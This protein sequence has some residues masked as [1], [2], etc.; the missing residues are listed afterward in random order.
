MFLAA[1]LLAAR[2]L[3]TASWSGIATASWFSCTS[4]FATA[5]WIGSSFA[6]ASRLSGTT[7]IRF[8]AALLAALLVA[9]EQTM[10]A[11]EQVVAVAGRNTAL[12]AT[13]LHMSTATFLAARL[14]AAGLLATT[15]WFASSGGIA[16]ASWFAGSSG[17]A[18]ATWIRSRCTA[19][20]WLGC[21]AR[22]FTTF[23]FATAVATMA[24][25]A[26]HAVQELEPE[27]LAT[28]THAEYQ[29][30]ENNVPF[31]RETSPLTVEPLEFAISPIA[32]RFT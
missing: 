8:A 19:T 18:T 1:R 11:T 21:T 4:W 31:H 22:F 29:R 24:I 26:D 25:Q 16:T 14:F 32:R 7:A 6:T 9:A 2:L 20:V 27:A 3:A 13:A 15:G 30:A 23:W 12:W 10:Q 28:Q 17:F 5:T